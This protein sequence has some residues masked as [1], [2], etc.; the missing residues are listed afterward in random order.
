MTIQ[1]KTTADNFLEAVNTLVK[2]NL[3]IHIPR[4]CPVR[5]PI[6]QNI[7][8]IIFVYIQSGKLH[9]TSNMFVITWTWTMLWYVLYLNSWLGWMRA[10]EKLYV[11]GILWYALVTTCLVHLFSLRHVNPTYIS[12]K[13]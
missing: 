6:L 8:P 10:V 2:G 5:I 9:R 7:F 12:L 1:K 3:L 13:I 11:L 4:A